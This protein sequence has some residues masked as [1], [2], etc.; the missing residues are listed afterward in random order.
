MKCQAALYNKEI[1]MN[2]PEADSA[3]ILC[4]SAALVILHLNCV[5]LS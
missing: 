2:K 3:G 1:K 5:S 4:Y